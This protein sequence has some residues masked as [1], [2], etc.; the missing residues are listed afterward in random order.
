[1]QLLHGGE[2]QSFM[3]SYHASMDHIAW[4]LI[5]L[6][7]LYERFTVQL[8]SITLLVINFYGPARGKLHLLKA[9]QLLVAL[10]VLN[11]DICIDIFLIRFLIIRQTNI[12]L[13]LKLLT[14]AFLSNSM[15]SSILSNFLASLAWSISFAI[16][17]SFESSLFFV[18]V[19]SNLAAFSASIRSHSA[20]AAYSASMRWHSASAALSSSISLR[21]ASAAFTYSSLKRSASASFSVLMRKSWPSSA[22]WALTRYSS[23]SATSSAAA[24]RS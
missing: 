20:S 9:T 4:H 16:S 3:E 5:C 12:K 18:L 15:A 23:A 8:K 13:V 17:S 7:R 1:M 11:V 21:F 10:S 24:R 2:L 6:A 22:F 14:M 19:S